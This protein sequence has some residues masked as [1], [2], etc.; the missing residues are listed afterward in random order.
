[1]EFYNMHSDLLKKIIPIL[2]EIF[3]KYYICHMIHRIIKRRNNYLKLITLCVS[4][5]SFA[6]SISLNHSFLLMTNLIS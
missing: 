6:I 5:G 1:M 4:F 2:N 3:V